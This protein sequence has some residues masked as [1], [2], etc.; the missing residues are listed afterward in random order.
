MGHLPPI[1]TSMAETIL[2]D[3]FT[4]RCLFSQNDL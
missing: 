3:Q 4:L 2:N 1:V